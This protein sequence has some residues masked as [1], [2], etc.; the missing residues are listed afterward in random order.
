MSFVLFS[1]HCILIL[2]TPCKIEQ[3]KLYALS[4]K[5]ENAVITYPLIIVIVLS[6]PLKLLLPTGKD[7]LLEFDGP[8]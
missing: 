4:L 6:N 2:I 3:E 5:I 7:S 8:V 1:L